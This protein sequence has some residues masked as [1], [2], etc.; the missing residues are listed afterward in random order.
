M[1]GGPAMGLTVGNGQLSSYFQEIPGHREEVKTVATEE[2]VDIK[3]FLNL[4]ENDVWTT[5]IIYP[6]DEEPDSGFHPDFT[7]H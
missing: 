6:S 1:W 2:S 5:K 7:T 3:K 4:R